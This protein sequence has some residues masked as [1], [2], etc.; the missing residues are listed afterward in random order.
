[1]R[2]A[3]VNRMEGASRSCVGPLGYL[4]DISRT[5]V[6]PGERATSEQWGLYRAAQDQ[7]MSNAEL[8]RPGV[9]FRE[10][11]QKCWPVPPEFI[12]NRY[13]M[14]VH[15]AG[16]VDE[17]PTIAY[18]SDYANWGYDGTFE[19]NTVVCVESYIGTAGGTQGVKLE[20][21]YLVTDAGAIPMF[22]AVREN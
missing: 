7:V 12:A 15:G 22:D 10:L 1:M 2:D 13:M 4:A 11:S 8:I 6:C 14:M 19:A 18:P 3:I 9:S 20:E 17:F 21:Q 16:L 5:L